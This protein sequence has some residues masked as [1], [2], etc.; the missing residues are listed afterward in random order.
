MTAR[1]LLYTLQAITDA[2]VLD[3]E[4]SWNAEYRL[5]EVRIE[6]GGTMFEDHVVLDE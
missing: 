1:E 5:G 2:A 4:V 3:R 6:G